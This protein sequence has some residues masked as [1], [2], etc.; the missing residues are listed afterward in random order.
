MR[1]QAPAGEELDMWERVPAE[2]QA[3]REVQYLKPEHRI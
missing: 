1:E 2:E 3:A